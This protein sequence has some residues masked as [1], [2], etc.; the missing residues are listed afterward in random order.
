MSV[1]GK[2]ISLLEDGASIVRFETETSV[3]ELKKEDRDSNQE[4]PVFILTKV[5]IKPGMSSSSDAGS[6]SR[7]NFLGT[8][9]TPEGFGLRLCSAV[10]GRPVLIQEWN[11]SPVLKIQ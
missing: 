4:G 6:S 7:G 2:I 10:V 8:I 3:Y 5:E 11:T 9:S 1:V